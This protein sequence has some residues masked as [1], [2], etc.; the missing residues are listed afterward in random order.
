MF[1]QLI[2]FCLEDH[3][4]AAAHIN[5]VFDPKG[6]HDLAD[7]IVFPLR[8]CNLRRITVRGA[9]QIDDIDKRLISCNLVRSESNQFPLRRF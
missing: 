3:D 8:T 4:A 6:D 7:P 5:R 9:F 1:G 2:C